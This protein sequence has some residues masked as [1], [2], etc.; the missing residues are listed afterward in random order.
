MAIA[1]QLIRFIGLLR[2]TLLAPEGE[3]QYAYRNIC[4]Y[5]YIVYVQMLK[6]Y[7]LFT[8]KISSHCWYKTSFKTFR[9]AFS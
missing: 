7:K 1:S 3:L 2:N 5:R 8:I 4:K 9:S 6:Y